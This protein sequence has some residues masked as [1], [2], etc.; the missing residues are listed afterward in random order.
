MTRKTLFIVIVLI[1]LAV[2]GCTE[3]GTRV[4][5]NN[6]TDAPANVTDNATAN[7]SGQ[8]PVRRQSTA[9]PLER[10]PFIENQ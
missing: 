2:S 6:S 8:D 1:G 9:I 7:A 5:D 10:P 4:A 3:N